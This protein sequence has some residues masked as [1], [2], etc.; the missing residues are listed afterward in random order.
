MNITTYQN[1]EGRIIS[2]RISV[3]L[4]KDENGKEIRRRTT[5]KVPTNLSHSKAKKYLNEQGVD[6]E[7]KCKEAGKRIWQRALV[8]GGKYSDELC[9]R[10]KAFRKRQFGA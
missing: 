9:A 10:S 2:G 5:V 1:K 7:R 3:Y 4:G 8:F 6:F